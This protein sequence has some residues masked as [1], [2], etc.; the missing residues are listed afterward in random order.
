MSI[1]FTCLLK[2]GMRVVETESYKNAEEALD[3]ERYHQRK[4]DT[5]EVP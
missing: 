5:Q 1:E 4:D 3:Q 2:H